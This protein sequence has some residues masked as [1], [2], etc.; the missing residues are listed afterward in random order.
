M[1][2]IEGL[3]KWF[4]PVHAVRDLTLSVPAGEVFAFLGPNGAGKTTTLKMLTGL[5]HPTSGRI[6]IA[7]YDMAKN[8][9]EARQQIAYIPDTPFLYDRLTATEFFHF[10]G[11]L[12]GLSRKEIERERE[13][14]FAF[15]GLHGHASALV[16][17]LSHGLRQR[18]AYAAALLHHPRVLFIDEPLIG[19]DPHSI[20][21]IK[22]LL[23]EKA[24]GGMTIFLTT[25]I[26]SLAEETADRI[27]IIHNGRL[28]ALG[29]LEEL[30]QRSGTQGDLEE[31]F[32]R[33]TGD[34]TI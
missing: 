14:T 16:K 25:H 9:I 4:G 24:A 7:G 11:T 23:R 6:R 13:A 26:L 1:I 22:G 17:D 27:G 32:L 2:E 33:L 30:R 21:A 34:D 19:L 5:L 29:P 20:R 10:V 31:V 28:I 8:P 18:L 12:Y 3:N 15:F